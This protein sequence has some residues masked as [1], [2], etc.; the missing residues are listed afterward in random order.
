MPDGFD[1]NDA[2]S[3]I[4]MLDPKMDCG[5][6]GERIYLLRE[7]ID[8]GTSSFIATGPVTSLWINVTVCDVFFAGVLP[9]PE[10]L[11]IDE[12]LRLTD[13]LLAAE[14]AFLSGHTLPQTIYSVLYSY[15]AA[16]PAAEWFQSHPQLPARYAHTFSHLFTFSSSQQ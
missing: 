6:G 10:A 15:L 11:S 3:A 9:S 5:A 1:L 2:M 13:L 7:K 12:V 8:R 16:E 4:E 14:A